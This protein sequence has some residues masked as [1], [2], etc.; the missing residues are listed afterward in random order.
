MSFLAVGGLQAHYQT[1]V[2]KLQ[3]ALQGLSRDVVAQPPTL[4]T[5]PVASKKALTAVMTALGTG[6]A[7]LLWVF[8]RQAWRN[9]E[10]NPEGA[11]KVARLR[12]TLAKALGRS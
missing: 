4:P 1:E 2:L 3:R 5:E 7:L 12:N 10:Q 9:A 8:M 6:F 11:Q